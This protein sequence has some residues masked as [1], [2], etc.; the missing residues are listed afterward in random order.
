VA[1]VVDGKIARLQHAEDL[2]SKGIQIGVI[3]TASMTGNWAGAA[4]YLRHAGLTQTGTTSRLP[5]PS[6]R[7]SP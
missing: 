1:T 2:I 3:L 6:T 5:K 7:R 4:R